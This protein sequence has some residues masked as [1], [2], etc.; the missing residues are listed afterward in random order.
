ML[1]VP[2]N[3][4]PDYIF[5]KLDGGGTFKEYLNAFTR[6]PG[7]LQPPGANK[8]V[9]YPEVFI[10]LKNNEHWSTIL[11][12][13]IDG[14]AGYNFYPQKPKLAKIRLPA[15]NYWIA[16]DFDDYVRKDDYLFVYKNMPTDYHIFVA[17]PEKYPNYKIYSSILKKPEPFVI[18]A[19]TI[20]PAYNFS[21][22]RSPPFQ[23]SSPP[24]RYHASHHPNTYYN[25][26]GRD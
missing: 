16:E 10:R 4:D 26:P 7:W 25:G 15:D 1:Y 21:A 17:M 22:P 18:P 9:Q 23:S 12:V 6:V 8:P 24:N 13:S 3:I 20:E 11:S 2:E 19:R 14:D 5:L